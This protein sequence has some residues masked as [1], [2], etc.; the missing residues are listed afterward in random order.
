MLD[1]EEKVV[2]HIAPVLRVMV[3]VIEV[4]FFN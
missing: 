3:G 4:P 2:G 1:E